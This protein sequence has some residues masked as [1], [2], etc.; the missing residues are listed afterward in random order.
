MARPGS[1][2]SVKKC[3][4]LVASLVAYRNAYSWNGA[5][6]TL[7]IAEHPGQVSRVTPHRVGVDTGPLDLQHHGHPRIPLPPSAI[8]GLRHLLKGGRDD[9]EGNGLLTPQFG[10]QA[11]IFVGQLQCERRGIKRLGEKVLGQPV[12]RPDTAESALANRRPE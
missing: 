5:G 4:C 3:C 10:Q 9:P 12:E 2:T 8:Q 11:D 1:S 6:T 7:A